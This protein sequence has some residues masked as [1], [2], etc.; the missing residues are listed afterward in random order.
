MK[1]ELTKIKLKGRKYICRHTSA[2]SKKIH[3]V[4]CNPFLDER[5]SKSSS[6]KASMALTEFLPNEYGYVALVLVFY[7]FLNLWMGAQVGMARKR[8]ALYLFRTRSK[9]FFVI[10]IF[11]SFVSSVVASILFHFRSMLLFVIL[12]QV[13]CAVSNSIRYRIRKQRC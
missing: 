8:F 13:Q 4:F 2:D 5:V 9:F 7:C 6:L 12:M 1:N 3:F 10:R 11:R